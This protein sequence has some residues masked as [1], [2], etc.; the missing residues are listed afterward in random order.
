MDDIYAVMSEQVNETPLLLAVL[1]DMGV[2]RVIDEHVGAHGNWQGVS[3]GTLTCI[4]LCHILSERQHRLVTVRDWAA[5]RQQT[6]EALLGVTLR[7]TDCT[8]DRLA[9]LLSMLGDVSVED[10]LDEALLADWMRVYVLPTKTV[11]LDTTSVSVYH[12]EGD[13]ESLLHPGYSKDHR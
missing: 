8:D 12:A 10:A 11:R 7:D 13:E 5:A 3:P 2:R 4:W 1:E 9:N 6:W